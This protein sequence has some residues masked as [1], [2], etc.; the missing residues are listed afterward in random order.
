[1]KF[2]QHTYDVVIIGGGAAGALAA[3]EAK[4]ANVSV[5]FITKETALVGGA[6][7]M[8]AGGTS[9]CMSEGD[10]SDIFVNDI[11]KSGQQ[12]NNTK[13][14][15]L[16]ADNSMEALYNLENGYFLLD[17][18]DLKRNGINSM[19]TTKKGE[20]HSFTR[21][22]LDRREALGFCHGIARAVMQHE[23][24]VFAET[25]AVK[26]LF[27]AG[28]AAGVVAFSLVTGEYLVFNAKSVIIA[29]GGLGALYE[30][31]TNSA[32]LTGDG[33]A[34]AFDLGIE[35]IDMEMIQFMPLCFPYPKTRRG[36]IIGMCSLFGPAVKLYNG[37]GKRYMGKY[38]PERWEQTTR[39]FCSRGN[40]N[41]IREG[42][43]TKNNAILVDATEAEPA[44]RERF[45][46]TNP[47][48]YKQC[49]QAFGQEA[50]DWKVRFE[51]IPAQHF[52]MGGIKI[53]EHSATSVPGV[54]A[55]GEV[56]G[57]VHGA[58]RLSGVALAEV[59]TLGPIAGKEAA[60]YAVQTKPTFFEA[61]EIAKELEAIDA[62]MR[63][64]DGGFRPFELKQK[65]R[66]VVSAYLG[67]IRNGEDL[68]AGI[69]ELERIKKEDLPKMVIA[70]EELR[71]NRDRM[72]AIEVPFMLKT[73]LAI[74]YAALTRKE[75]RGAHF[76]QDF[77][78]KDDQNWLKN[79]G[80]KSGDNQKFEINIHE[81]V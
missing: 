54:F 48:R 40:F 49:V 31:T 7:I 22:Y 11:K 33:F 47:F 41:E 50:A 23:V 3:I 73:A 24:A 18:K 38:D 58:N 55:V 44:V 51:A 37:L 53:D 16:V 46:Q 14:A 2:T 65:I 15:H 21:A 81:I 25:I 34:M 5:A 12:I 13:L 63:N 28:C 8:A 57:G 52:C 30:D 80:V 26:I 64:R 39:D 61:D 10:N 74:S 68:K 66:K 67:P 32:V 71:Y 77:P 17:R 79:I 78:G 27:K 1:M 4:K 75:S 29:T 9:V 69:V 60:K 70:S 72:E 42:R 59:F 45:K 20:G 62:P 35:L 76:R 43:G 6:T 56:T 19:H 36:K